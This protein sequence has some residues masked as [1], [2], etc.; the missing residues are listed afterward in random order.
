MIIKNSSWGLNGTRIPSRSWC[1]VDWCHHI[2]FVILLSPLDSMFI[3]WSVFLLSMQIPM[4]SYLIKLWPG[5]SNFHHPTGTKY[6]LMQRLDLRVTKF[7][8]VGPDPPSP[9]SWSKK[10]IYFIA[11]YPASLGQGN[12]YSIFCKSLPIFNA[13][14][15]PK[16]LVFSITHPI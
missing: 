4:P 6:L 12:I 14:K 8:F 10:E 3:D 16:N 5:N 7:E 11:N 13:F 1:M 9:C 2:Y 15:M